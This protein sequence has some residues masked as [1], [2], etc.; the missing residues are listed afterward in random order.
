MTRVLAIVL[1]IISVQAWAEDEDSNPDLIP[2]PEQPDIPPPV[3]SGQNMEPDVTIVRKGKDIV[4]E[5]RINN[6]LF[7]VKIRPSIGPSYY[8]LDND[9]DGD[10]ES[11]RNDIERGANGMNIPQWVL[12]SW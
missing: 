5:Y 10:F 3:Q 4:E 7:M 1:L 2:L 6:R 9:G 11:K 12:F 8:L